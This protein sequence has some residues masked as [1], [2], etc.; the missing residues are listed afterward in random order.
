MIFVGIDWA[1]DHHDVCIVAEHG[2]VLDGFRVVDGLEGIGQLHARLV[3]HVD[4][5]EEIVVGL[6]TDRGLVVDALVAAGYQLYAI[7]P[8]SVS[9]YRDRHRVSGAKSDRGDTKVAA[10]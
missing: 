8:L 10:W 9:R 5:P 2:E 4:Q 6:E 3:D 1:E 7:N